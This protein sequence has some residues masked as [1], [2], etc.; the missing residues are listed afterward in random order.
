MLP[1]N[2]LTVIEPICNDTHVLCQ[3]WGRRHRRRRPAPNHSG[4]WWG[5]SLPGGVP[6]PAEKPRGNLTRVRR[7]DQTVRRADGQHPPR[8][9]R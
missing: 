5:P 7:G 9:Q 1:L 3:D 8:A 2:F 6:T 4:A